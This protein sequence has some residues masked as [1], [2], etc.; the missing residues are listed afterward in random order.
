MSPTAKFQANSMIDDIGWNRTENSMEGLSEK[1][2]GIE[3]KERVGFSPTPTISVGQEMQPTV[4]LVTSS[5]QLCIQI[6]CMH[7]AGNKEEE[8]GK[9]RRNKQ[10]RNYADELLKKQ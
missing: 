1:D 8:R 9:E 4:A 10:Q 6:D 7:Q 3:W 2:E 5:Q